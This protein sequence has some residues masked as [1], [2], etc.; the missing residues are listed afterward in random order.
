MSCK[1]KNEKK[2]NPG[3]LRT[4]FDVCEPV[5]PGF[6]SNGIKSR[7]CNDGNVSSVTGSSYCTPCPIGS[8]EISNHTACKICPVNTYNNRIGM[9]GEDSCLACPENTYTPY[10]GSSMCYTCGDGNYLN[11]DNF[12]E[13][14]PAGKQLVDFQLQDCP[15]G[16]YSALGSFGECVSVC[17]IGT[18]PN[19]KKCEPCVNGEKW[20][21]GDTGT[22]GNCAPCS[23]EEWCPEGTLQPFMG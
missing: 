9:S 22:N 15:D 10:A 23:E 21:P 6:W 11:S 4:E 18:V 1:Y 8:F 19:G 17:P 7:E 12:C 16:K 20:V 5:P 2:C 14:I 13:K 3:Y